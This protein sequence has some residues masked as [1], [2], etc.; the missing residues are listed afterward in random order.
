MI[1]PEAIPQ[2]T[3]DLGQ[4]EKDHASLTTDA[5]HIRDTGSSVHTHFQALSAYYKAPEAERLFAST[6]PV[7]DR[8]DGF[9]D[10][11]EKVASS[12][13]DY[14]TEI[15]PLVTKLTQLKADATT[16]V[17]D[18]KDDD[19]WEYDGDKVEEHNQLR[20]DITATVAAFWAAERTCHNKI[21]ALFGG[22]QMVAGDG[23]ERKDQYGFDA[24]D[25]KNAKLPWGDPVEEKHH[26]YEV[27]HWV[28]SFVW[29]GL[30]VD[31]IWG[32][33]KGLGTLVGFGGW[34]AMG[35]AWKGL[36]QL[37]TGLA[38][39]AIPGASTL[40]WTLPDDKLPSWLRDS[41]TA[42]KE[43][44]KALVAWDEW[45]KNPGRAAGAVT[46][47][48]LTT[49]FTGGA[50]G[51][52][53][54]A[55]KAGAVAKVLSV[56]GKAG[57]VIDPMTY[58][59]KGAGA[60]LSKI[61]DITKGLKG[62]SNIEIPKLPDD[63][64][65]LPEGSLKL[66]DGT[67]HLPD[68]APIPEGGVKLPD[69]NIKFPDDAPLLP[70]NTTKLPTHTDVPVQ[71]FDHDGN[72]LNEHGDTVQHAKDAPAETSPHLPDVENTVREPALVGAG[73]HTATDVGHM[74]DDAFGGTTHPA[75]HPSGSGTGHGGDTPSHPGETPDGPAHPH[76]GGS[77]EPEHTPDNGPDEPHAHDSDGH[78]PSPDGPAADHHPTPDAGDGPHSPDHDADMGT[79]RDYEARVSPESRIP[80]QPKEPGD[81]ILDTGDPVYFGDG[82]TAVGYDRSTRVNFDLVEP[83]PGYHD[84]VVHGNNQGFFEPGR[85][86]EAGS[87]F[88][89]GD[90]HPTHI[91]DAI[92]ANPSYD[93]GPVRLVSCHTGT[94]GEGVLDIPAAQ[95]VANELGVPVMA[96]TNKVGVNTKL[97]PNQ[98]PKIFGGG[99]WRTFLPMAR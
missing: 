1:K 96:P 97:G 54:G 56:A 65:T 53:A 20:D 19:D 81:L 67:V 94:A 7:Q 77:S 22:T 44:G 71:Y 46:F 91:A 83:L 61:G 37:A 63:A 93:G 18:N 72:L 66:P 70:E 32:T 90:T 55:G 49:V 14:A 82:R 21:T 28:K 43:T 35:Q 80:A 11:L 64:I 76:E 58:I 30:I 60:G 68:G 25:L 13:S 45:G 6:K 34:D 5:G 23:S 42:M 92:R 86:N 89:A 79:R 36:A 33:I 2:Y 9:A 16:F 75:D 74:G 85:V 52:A 95:A 15:R 10:D 51:A 48:V 29:D 24:D 78:Q 57:K 38:I 31:G 88:S 62:I 12:L 39:S 84:V 73:T 26:W 47:N 27:G 99:Y 17:N 98:I 87:S 69:G 4:L 3:G 8:A 41:R 50:G 59:A 40:F